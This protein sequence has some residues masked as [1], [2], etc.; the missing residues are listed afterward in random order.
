MRAGVKR[1]GHG[2]G[3]GG[4]RDEISSTIEYRNLPPFEQILYI[5]TTIEYFTAQKGS[6]RHNLNKKFMMKLCLFSSPGRNLQ[7]ELLYYP[8]RQRWRRRRR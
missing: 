8:R 7:E 2:R 1:Q 6:N 4:R 3:G 5:Q